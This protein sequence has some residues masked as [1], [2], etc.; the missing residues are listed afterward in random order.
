MREIYRALKGTLQR[1]GSDFDHL[2]KATYHV[3]DN[4]AGNKLNEIRPQYYKPERPPAASKA[5]VRGVGMAEK[6]VMLDMIAVPK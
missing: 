5:N 1:T 3:T 4:E 6:T 2:V